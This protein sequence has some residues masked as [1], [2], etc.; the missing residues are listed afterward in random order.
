MEGIPV[1]ADHSMDIRRFTDPVW[2]GYLANLPV[3]VFKE[4]YERY[5]PPQMD[6]DN[7][8]EKYGVH[9]DPFTPLKEKVIYAV[10]ANTKYAVEENHRVQLFSEL[11][12]GAALSVSPRAYVMMGELMYQSHYAYTECGLG[13]N[14]TDLLVGLCRKQG[15]A[16]GI[17][18]AKITGGAAP[19]RF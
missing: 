6:R 13:A 3:S 17:Y 1:T 8:L 7:Y 12:K 14:A 11:S 18:G 10:H 5:L 4:K 19:S 9:V 16:H 2:N 15:I